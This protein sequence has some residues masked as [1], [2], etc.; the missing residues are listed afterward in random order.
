MFYCL[1][2]TIGQ[3]MMGCDMLGWGINAN[4]THAGQGANLTI[5]SS[6]KLSIF[7]IQGCP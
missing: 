7:K 5:S 4:C 3:S 2:S 6:K 1:I